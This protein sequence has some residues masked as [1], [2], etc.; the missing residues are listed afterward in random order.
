[1]KAVLSLEVADEAALLGDRAALRVRI[2]ARTAEWEASELMRALQRRGVPAALVL[3]SR[4]LFEDPQLRHRRF[5]ETIT[6][7]EAGTHDYI[8][9]AWKSD[10]QPRP[11]ARPAPLLGEHTT[12]VLESI[13]GYSAAQIAA[14]AERGVTANDPREL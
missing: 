11:P 6:H 7:P 8:G 13:L 10:R 9:L 1:V 3:D 2:A 12:Y 5:F 14:L 4:D